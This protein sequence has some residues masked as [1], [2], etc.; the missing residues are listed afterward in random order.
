MYSSKHRL[1]SPDR[2][3]G[4]SQLLTAQT[5]AGAHEASDIVSNGGGRV[6]EEAGELVPLVVRK[7]GFTDPLKH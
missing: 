1:E 5:Q 3:Q 7:H 6:D 2:L 4:L